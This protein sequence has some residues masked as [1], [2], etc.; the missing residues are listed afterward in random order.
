MYFLFLKIKH[1]LNNRSKWYLEF[2]NTAQ[3]HQKQQVLNKVIFE[4][5]HMQ[6]P[7]RPVVTKV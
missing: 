1:Q 7:A 4:I 3:V 6:C 5:L 2:I